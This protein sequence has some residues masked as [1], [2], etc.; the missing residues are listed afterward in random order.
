MRY[1]NLAIITALFFLILFLIFGQN[2]F[3]LYLEQKTILLCMLLLVLLW[4][5]DVLSLGMD[6]KGLMTSGGVCPVVKSNTP[7]IYLFTINGLSMLVI[8]F[9]LYFMN[10][11]IRG[12]LWSLVL[13]LGVCLF[14]V[15]S[16]YIGKFGKSS[17]ILE[18]SSLI[19]YHLI[20]LL[21]IVPDLIIAILASSN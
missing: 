10:S 17:R 21:I 20:L 1:Y 3:N 4:Y 14:L 5:N 16:I 2:S 8:S 15:I 6:L 12:G 13:L 19:L 18:I 7:A 9:W 11:L